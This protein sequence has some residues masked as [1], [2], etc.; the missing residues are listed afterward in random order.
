MEK[1]FRILAIPGSLRK[2]SYNKWALLA[3]EKLKPEGVDFEI[4]SLDGI[5]PYNQDE[6]FNL[7][8]RVVVFKRK[9]L[10]SDAILI[11][12]PE[13][14]YSV[15]GVLKNAID[16]A[17]RPSGES[18]WTGK[19]VAVLG[20]SVS[21]FGSARAQY[22]LRQIFVALNMLSLNRP[23]V[24]IANAA[25]AFGKDGE[26]IDETSRKMIRTLLEELLSLAT[27]V[28]KH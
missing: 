14:N 16:F 6:E 23:E 26:L 21:A 5:P 1:T 9:I 18:A 10:E 24:M 13:Y 22:H 2:D 20:A 15:P 11:S 17:S 28:R 19:P 12:T 27:Q 7:P 8:A 25:K 4:F 3:A